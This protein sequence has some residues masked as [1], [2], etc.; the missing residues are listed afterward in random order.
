MF[1]ILNK[2][3]IVLYNYGPQTQYKVWKQTERRRREKQADCLQQWK[4]RDYIH[5]MSFPPGTQE[6]L[7]IV[8]SLWGQRTTFPTKNP[9]LTTTFI[10][11]CVLLYKLHTS[12]NNLQSVQH[13]GSDSV[14]DQPGLTEKCRSGQQ[15][16]NLLR[17]SGHQ[18]LWVLVA[19]CWASQCGVN[20]SIGSAHQLCRLTENLLPAQTDKTFSGSYTHKTKQW[21]GLLQIHF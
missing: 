1:N 14:W 8:M 20:L 7:Y 6:A 10:Y 15:G 17:G 18:V 9:T 16:L 2:K 3:H 4:W 21:M 12:L 5:I 19:I 13:W 11:I